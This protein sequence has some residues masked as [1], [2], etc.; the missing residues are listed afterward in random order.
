MPTWRVEGVDRFV[1]M[2]VAVFMLGAS[3]FDCGRVNVGQPIDYLVNGLM[4]DT[5]P[6]YDCTLAL[7]I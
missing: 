7:F 5:I 1:Y 4:H 2:C 3:Q 6:T